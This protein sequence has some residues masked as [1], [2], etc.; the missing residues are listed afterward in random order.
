[1]SDKQPRLLTTVASNA[2]MHQQQLLNSSNS[3]GQIAAYLSNKSGAPNNN[4]SNSMKS[5][6]S[7][8]IALSVS[9]SSYLTVNKPETPAQ[10][11]D[12]QRNEEPEVRAVVIS[13]LKSNNAS[14][15]NTIDQQVES[16]KR[17]K[18]NHSR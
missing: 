11:T 5:I 1:M 6:E 7:S 15:N 14:M 8:M 12:I 10:Q 3:Q 13:S 2:Q 17:H 16:V 4:N 18:K 9:L